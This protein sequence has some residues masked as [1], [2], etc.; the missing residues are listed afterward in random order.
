MLLKK[1]I[2]IA[3]AIAVCCIGYFIYTLAIANGEIQEYTELA[4]K[5]TVI[6]EYKTEMKSSTTQ[7]ESEQNTIKRV[8][9]D[10]NELQNLNNEI[11]GWVAIPDTIISYPVLQTTNNTKYL[12]TSAY[13]KKSSAG[14]VFLDFNNSFEPLDDNIIVYGHNMGQG[15]TDM[16]STLLNYKSEDY[17]KTH[18]LVQFDTI[19]KQYEF[20][21]IFAVIHLDTRKTNGFNYLRIQF[22]DDAE[23]QKYIDTAKQLSLYKTDVTPTTTDSLLTLMTCDRSDYGKTG[24]LLV[25]AKHPKSA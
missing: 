5:Y 8:E 1:I 25:I 15:R 7:S 24:R 19:S 16:F 12:K 14:A 6:R 23:H 13:N 3:I 18:P 22:A 4:E 2:I 10:F 20:W 21:E 11:M 9:T 17:Y